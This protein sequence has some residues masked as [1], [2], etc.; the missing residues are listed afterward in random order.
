M[1]DHK[2]CEAALATV[3]SSSGSKE[4]RGEVFDNSFPFTFLKQRN[5][6]QNRNDATLT[7]PNKA[8]YGYFFR[9]EYSLQHFCASAHWHHWGSS[10]QSPVQSQ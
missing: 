6:N 7:T 5:K 8:K 9:S 10:V 2:L 4:E 3:M 1:P